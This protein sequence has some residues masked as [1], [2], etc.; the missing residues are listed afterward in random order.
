MLQSK[1]QALT[2]HSFDIDSD[3]VAELITGWS[4][5]KVTQSHF[6]ISITSAN[7]CKGTHC[8]QGQCK[9][10]RIPSPKNLAW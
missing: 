9:A 3:G 8:K 6:L 2:I 7:I 1:N 10:W 4:N 5:G